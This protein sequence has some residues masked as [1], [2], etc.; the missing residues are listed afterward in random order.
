M[1]LGAK[2]TLL[3]PEPS[4]VPRSLR[5]LHVMLGRG[6]SAPD[7]TASLR[8]DFLKSIF[9]LL[10]DI[11]PPP[12]PGFPVLLKDSACPGKVWNKGCSTKWWRVA[13]WHNESGYKNSHAG[14][15]SSDLFGAR[16]SQAGHGGS[17]PTLL[18]LRVWCQSV[19]KCR[20]CVRKCY[21]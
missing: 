2:E 4:A 12:L 19:S 13:S 15:S 18:I 20:G 8:A 1:N 3:H 11:R 10:Q 7:Y 5:W 16:S 17:N 21:S 14:S 6:G 9:P